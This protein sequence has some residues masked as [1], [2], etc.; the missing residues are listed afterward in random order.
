[1]A[2]TVL[3]SVA[4]AVVAI[5]LD[6]V[7]ARV[8][9]ARRFVWIG[10][11]LVST[12]VPT[13]IALRS[14]V[15]P[16]DVAGASLATADGDAVIENVR[17]S[18][19]PQTLGT[20]RRSALI[21]RARFATTR[22]VEALNR[23]ATPSWLV[24]SALGFVA[25]FASIARLAWRR[26]GWLSAETDVGT[27]L[28]SSHDGPAVVGAIRPTIVI[29]QWALAADRQA[30]TMVLQHELEHLRAHD[31]RVLLGLAVLRAAFPWNPAL[32]LIARRLRRAIEID[33]DARVIH[34]LGRPHAYGRMLVELSERYAAPLPM[35][36]LLSSAPRDLEAR[37][38]A[39]TGSPT[40]HRVGLSALIALG[41]VVLAAWLPLP[42]VLRVVRVQSTTA[43]AVTSPP[44]STITRVLASVTKAD[45]VAP[46]RQKRVRGAKVYIGASPPIVFPGGPRPLRGNPAPK[47]P[48]DMR[49]SR[50]EGVVSVEFRIDSA[51][52]PDTS[53]LRV[54]S[55]P[56]VAFERSVRSV[57]PRWRFDSGGML[58]IAFKFVALDR[59][60]GQPI[61]SGGAYSADAD[62]LNLQPVIVTTL[63]DSLPSR[64]REH[65][66]QDSAVRRLFSAWLDAFNSA[67]STKI[68]VF[69]DE[70]F[71]PNS[72]QGM[73]DLRAETRGLILV[74]IR[75]AQPLSLE[76]VV[77][78]RNPVPGVIATRVGYFAVAPN[79]SSRVASL[80]LL[81]VNGN[82]TPDD[83]ALIAHLQE[84]RP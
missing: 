18:P 15:I 9:L 83:P 40:R 25:I 52:V 14:Q 3:V 2:W 76:F 32:W 1:M 55:S 30:R 44:R 62:R 56:N 65:E 26:R 74:S 33:C 69:S 50:I 34:A 82:R 28:I 66:E 27:V 13:A 75:R 72:L 48:D 35:S 24:A 7:S 63:V 68:A 49:D 12:L 19:G 5:A 39:M 54:I 51:G 42:P 58:T 29:P 64:P 20:T 23:W 10:A 80:R 16:T 36:A 84:M 57:L 61:K 45:S 53:S 59:Q 41:A 37:I 8:G 31:S 6:R 67:D 46:W 11:M 21:E 60:T 22:S 81:Y 43:P 17:W 71:P 79:D 70:H 77:D 38:E 4:V 78:A 47:Y 73:K